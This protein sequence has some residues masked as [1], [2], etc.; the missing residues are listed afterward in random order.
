M[1]RLLLLICTSSLFFSCFTTKKES[2]REKENGEYDNPMIRDKEEADKMIDPALGYVPYDRLYDAMLYT[3]NLKNSAAN[4][5]QNIN[6]LSWIERGPIYDSVGPSNGNGRGGGT[7]VTGAYT[8][9]R[10]RAFLLDTLNDPTGNTAFCGGVAGGLWKCNNFL[11]TTVNWVPVN[12]FFDNL[13]IA[14]ICQNPVTPS[15]IYFATGEAT[16]NADAAFGKGV[17]KSTNSGA[18]FSQLPTT[19]SFIRNY[20]IACD[21]AGNVYLACRVT[22]T[23]VAQPNGLM[24]STD[25]GASWVNITPAGLTSNL[26]CTDIEFTSSGK[27][28][29][30]FGYLGTVVNHRYTAN[31][32]T[33]TPGAGWNAGNGFRVSNT[34]AVFTELAVSGDVLY[35]V[36]INTAYNTDSCYKSVDGGINWTKQNSTVMPTGLGSGQGWYNLTV[37]INPANTSELISGGLDAYRSVN[38][39]QSW[40]RITYWVST[41][42]Y[43]HADHHY[44]QYWLKN[45]ETRLIIASDGGIYY[46][47]NNGATFVDKNK[48]LSLKQFYGIAIHPAAGSPYLLAGAQDNGVHQLKNPGLSYSIEVTG[49]DGCITHINQQDPQIQFGSYVYNQYRRSTNGGATWGSVNLSGSAGLFVNPFDYDDGQNIMY[50]SNGATG[51]IRRWPSA[52]T[53]N[54][55]TTIPIAAVGAANSLTAFKVSPYTANRVFLGTN[56]GKVYKLEN[57]ATVVA[58]DIDANTTSIG[59]ASFPTGTINC[60]NTGTN[61][62]NLVV[63][64]TNYGVNNV[65]VTPDGGTTWTAIDGNLPDMPIRWALYE[66]GNNTKMYLATETGVWATNLINGASTLWVPENGV[67]NVRVSAIKLR[68]SDSTI[69][70]GTYGR[71]CFTA[72]IPALCITGSL[73]SQPSNVNTCSGNTAVFTVSSSGNNMNY[74]WQIST[75]GGTTY[76]NITGEVAPAL[77]L[78]NVTPAMNNNRYRCVAS[79]TCTPAITSNA[80]TLTVTASPLITTQPVNTNVC[81]GS[82]T[83]F[84]IAG[85]GAGISYQWQISTNGGATFSNITGANATTFPIAAPTVSMDGY[86]YR[87]IITGTCLPAAVSDVVT[88]SVNPLPTVTL[89]ASPYQRIYPGISTYLLASVTPNAGSSY[90]WFKNNVIVP[91]ATADFLQVNVDGIGSYKV[92]ATD[93]KG[94]SNTSNIVVIGDSVINKLFIYPNP[95]TGNFQVRYFTNTPKSIVIYDAVGAKV[96]AQTYAS[97]VAYDKMAVDLSRNRSGVYFLVLMDDKGKRIATGKV[98]VH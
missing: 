96:F 54:V 16:S 39:G 59:G 5:P 45:G 37:A 51:Q 41:A 90:V 40:T 84:N 72:K 64:F 25:G 70:A 7:G 33:V 44:M 31:P 22:T 97:T 69:A 92:T 88:L 36:T 86:Q 8:S 27:L 42:P 20:K 35:A 38:D 50:C 62:N 55:S 66:P 30:M 9:G 14:S 78:A 43:V 46:S 17:W 67:P 95:N 48:N 23:P 57:A 10:M 29:A 82:S 52:N 91:G 93:I 89:I 63:V 56:N 6:G 2:R 75:N 94:C 49:G 85:S 87:C 15:I 4:S 18:T 81:I 71:G 32:S 34:A 98:F 65:W 13:A 26:T 58:A 19:T 74:Q 21:A 79:S 11:S 80:A 76:T 28:N 68:A 83:S 77:T 53:L 61:D 47:T 60:I 24:R 73:T 1:K 12:D 3:E